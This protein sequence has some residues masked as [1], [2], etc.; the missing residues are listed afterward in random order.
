MQAAVRPHH[1]PVINRPW[2]SGRAER[3]L[4]N[5]HDVRK[6]R[7]EFAW[8]DP[9]KPNSETAAKFPHHEVSAEG[10]IGPANARAAINGIA[11]L[12]GGRGGAEIP[13]RDRVAIY[14]HLATHILDAGKEPPPLKG[15]R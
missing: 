4:P 11:I 14:R 9:N 1:T 3:N 6:L 12:N 8:I 10:K 5:D 15:L 2:D 13:E 7:R